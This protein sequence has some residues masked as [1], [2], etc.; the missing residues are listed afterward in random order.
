MRKDI[1]AILQTRYPYNAKAAQHFGAILGEYYGSGHA[2]PNMIAELQTQDDGKYWAHIWE[3]I[4]YKHLKTLGLSFIEERVNK[5][6]QKGPDF[7]INHSGKRVWIEAIVPSPTGIPSE[8]LKPPSRDITKIEAHEVPHQQKLLRWTAAI[9]EKKEKI[10]GYI[11]NGVISEDDSVVIAVNSCRLQDFDFDDSG[12][13]RLPYAV[14]AT[15]PVGPLAI[16]IDRQGR[17][18]GPAQNTW[19]EF[20]LNKNDKEVRTDNFLDRSHGH[21]SAVLGTH[22]RDLWSESLYLSLVHNPLAKNPMPKQILGSTK[23]FLC[24]LGTDVFML[25]NLLSD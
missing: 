15:F 9:K 19:R 17:P 21:I 3:A 16:P 11:I 18:Q 23:E 10:A 12:I 6:G 4:L 25:R 14:E 2:P 7:G 8:Y 20:V 13:S 22:Q 24:E 5:S 1:W